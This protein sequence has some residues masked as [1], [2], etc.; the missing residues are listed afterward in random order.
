M[1][2]IENA[3]KFHKDA[4]II[5]NYLQPLLKEYFVQLNTEK[6][7]I[8]MSSFTFTLHFSATLHIPHSRSV[9]NYGTV[10]FYVIDLLPISAKRFASPF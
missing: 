5:C 3:T 7:S 8:T 4:V 6:L 10:H 9:T 1:L 2:I